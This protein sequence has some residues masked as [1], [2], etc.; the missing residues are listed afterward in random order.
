MYGIFEN[1]KKE[2]RK[3]FFSPAVFFKIF[4]MSDENKTLF[5]SLYE[6]NQ[7]YVL[8]TLFFIFFLLISTRILEKVKSSKHKKKRSNMDKGRWLSIGEKFFF[9]TVYPKGKRKYPL[10]C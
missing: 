2:K 1:E 5:G 10:F 6:L 4:T 7:Q 9:S 3:V 8:F